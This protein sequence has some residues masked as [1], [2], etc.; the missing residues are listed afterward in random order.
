MFP[1]GVIL[2]KLVV[3]NINLR[4]R[5]NNA[6]KQLGK[7]VDSLLSTPRLKNLLLKFVTI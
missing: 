7:K 1:Q 2:F 5:V 4:C 3:Y 6:Q